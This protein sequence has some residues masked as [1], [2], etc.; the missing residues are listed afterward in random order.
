[1]GKGE[2]ILT[3][4]DWNTTQ[5]ILTEG[6]SPCLIV[7]LKTFHGVSITLTSVVQSQR[8]GGGEGDGGL[9]VDFNH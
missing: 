3:S 1:M 9:T 7:F 2:P 6:F 8:S 5:P 4:G